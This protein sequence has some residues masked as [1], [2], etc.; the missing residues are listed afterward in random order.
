LTELPDA[1]IER[2]ASGSRETSMP[3]PEVSS[4]PPFELP[5]E[6]DASIDEVVDVDAAAGGVELRVAAR[7]RD[8]DRAAG[9]VDRQARLGRHA[10]LVLDAVV[11]VREPGVVFLLRD[12]ARRAGTLLEAED[13]ELVQVPAT[14][15]DHDVGPG[16]G[17]A[18]HGHGADVRLEAELAAR[19]ELQVLLDA[20]LGEGRDGEESDQARQGRGHGQCATRH[21][22]FPLSPRYAGDGRRFPN[23]VRV[24]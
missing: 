9:R 2:S 8:L 14:G 21:G 20:V 15:R 23:V 24:P 16:V 10:D 18:G 13:Q 17:A 1:W 6:N 4:V 12:D 7:A 19:V 11:G 22:S 5:F 3:P